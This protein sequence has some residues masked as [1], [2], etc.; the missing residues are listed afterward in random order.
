MHLRRVRVNHSQVE[1]FTSYKGVKLES[2]NQQSLDRFF[3]HCLT[4]R[5]WGGQLLEETAFELGVLVREY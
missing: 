1:N 3:L 4:G 2:K 5:R